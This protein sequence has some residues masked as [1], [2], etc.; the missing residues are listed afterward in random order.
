[1]IHE[2][3]RNTLLPSRV[4]NLLA[5][6]RPEHKDTGQSGADGTLQPRA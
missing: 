6:V 2:I 4:N 1:L 3:S 5:S